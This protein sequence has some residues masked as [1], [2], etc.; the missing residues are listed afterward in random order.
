MRFLLAFFIL[1]P[2]TAFSQQERI[3]K[4]IELGA[5]PISYK[6]D[7]SQGY[8]KWGS[9][10]HIGIKRNNKKR[11]NGHFNVMIG[12]VSGQ[13]VNYSYPASTAIPNQFF[14]ARL[15]TLNYDLQYNII[16]KDRFI[17]YISQGI[18]LMRFSP[19]DEDNVNLADK[20]NTRAKDESFNNISFMLPHYIGIIYF[21]KNYYGVGFQIGRLTPT[22]DYLDNI[23]Q[24]STY[25]KPDNI[26]SVK[27]TVYAPLSYK[28]ENPK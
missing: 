12:S 1:L 24:L 11:M 2:F 8:Q 3:S 16:K 25:K 9:G 10:F 4:F 17:F 21:L 6:G 15:F 14:K 26:L 13:N 28:K 23:S 20:F 18:G 7:L 5:S 22:T 19:K 27:F